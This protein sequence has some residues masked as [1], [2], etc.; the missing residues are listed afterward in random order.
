MKIKCREYIW[1]QLN[2]LANLASKYELADHK[3]VT[4]FDCVDFAKTQ[5]IEKSSV[6]ICSISAKP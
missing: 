1:N 4:D 2:R 6:H 5:S 3:S